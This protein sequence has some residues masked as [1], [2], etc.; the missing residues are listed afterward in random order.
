MIGPRNAVRSMPPD[1]P[2]EQD[3][4]G[5][6]REDL[7]V[8]RE[9][10]LSSLLVA[11][12]GAS[13]GTGNLRLLSGEPGVGKTRLANEV[14]ASAARAGFE[15]LVGQCLEHYQSIPF[16]GFTEALTGKLPTV[17]PF[18]EGKL[19]TDVPDLSFLPSQGA[20][21]PFEGHSSLSMFR[22]ITTVLRG[23]AADRPLALLLEDLHWADTA[24]IGAVVY[25]SGHLRDTR[26]LVLGTYRDAEVGPR[27]PL[28][29]LLHEV[30]R[31]DLLEEL[32]LNNLSLTHITQLVQVR[33]GIERASEELLELI[34]RRTGGNPLFAQEM[35][36]ALV[37]QGVFD[38]H[39]G[40]VTPT[41]IPD[42]SLPRSV[43][44]IVSQRVRRLPPAAQELVQLTSVLGVEFEL[45]QL[46][47][48]S[49]RSE[50][51]LVEDLD[52]LVGAKLVEERQGGP[53]P[54]LAFSH[55]L[56]QQAVYEDL[57]GNRRRL[58]HR[59][60]ADAL[61][62][63]VGNRPEAWV[64]MAR[65][66][67]GAG[68]RDRALDYLVLA[69]D[70][71]AAL[72]AHA[73]AARH[74]TVAVE[75]ATD[76]GDDS[77][78]A[79]L[80]RKL[81]SELGDLNQPTEAIAAY[82]AALTYYQA[83]HNWIEEA[84]LHREIAWIHQ[85]GFNFDSALPHLEIA[86]R[87]WAEERQDTEF[88]RLL[89]D[90]ARMYGFVTEFA[91]ARQLVDRGLAVAQQLGD[92]AL[93]ARGLLESA[94][95]HTH[96]GV[97][98]RLLLSTFNAAEVLAER[99]GD[100]RTLSRLHSGRAMA[101]FFAG[102]L[103]VA[104][105]E[106]ERQLDAANRAGL[107]DR[108]AFAAGMVATTC[109]E[110]G[111]WAEGR[112]AARTARAADPH[113]IWD[114]MLPWQEGNFTEALRAAETALWTA[115]SRRDVQ[116]EVRCL[117]TLADWNLQ[118]ERG[119][120]ALARA[121][122]A[123]ELV[124]NRGYLGWA[125]AAYGPFA[126]GAVRERVEDAHAILA[127]A[128]AC[129]RDHEQYYALP[130]LLRARGLLLERRGNRRAALDALA[131][132]AHVARE[133]QALPQL[134]RTLFDLIRVAERA[135]RSELVAASQA[136]HAATLVHIGTEP[137]GLY[138]AT[139]HR[140]IE[141]PEVGGQGRGR[142][143]LV[144]LSSREREVALLISRGRTNREIAELLV[145]SERT[146]GNHVERIFNKLGLR[147]RTQLVAWSA[148]HRLGSDGPHA[149]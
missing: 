5:L 7:F 95:L 33:L 138:W 73:E 3:R 110:L 57:S 112:V 32:P 35:F 31:N 9:S 99:A 114:F 104:R 142:P 105:T 135:G 27:H 53:R 130:Q 125:A 102:R 11:L 97:P 40:H 87:M 56:L 36:K 122:E 54:R 47:A 113:P 50:S 121:R 74:Y 2:I 137:G 126:E 15:T 39:S 46:V 44:S 70:H 55:E 101:S 139:L 123:V 120:A 6:R 115:R 82:E 75:L 16:F 64:D 118:L 23:L 93:Q 20:V 63:S 26:L 136:E 45:S 71:A 48:V 61:E 81:G 28:Q 34:Y 128:E 49:P 117:T 69:A 8:G 76:R 29:E 41:S 72:Y 17:Q 10:E 58:L 1:R 132:S 78:T 109:M 100:R 141:P 140:S 133:Q 77:A 107:P 92:D 124:L 13:R 147:S 103:I 96:E 106:Y 18:V 119:A 4:S 66:L 85:R 38:P 67:I 116:A 90:A 84:R 108:V 83:Q 19:S 65:H 37:E 14:L 80:R 143:R 86:L 129:V 51:E 30:V 88:V 149:S 134:A 79:D 127:E 21:P 146:V 111:D 52:A 89:F 22:A 60:V 59:A 43:R 148:E 25:L 42:I 145:I 144:E 131:E 94:G 12:E 62:R 68:E 98:I 24:T 91:T